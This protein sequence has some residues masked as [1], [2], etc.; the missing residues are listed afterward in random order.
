MQRCLH[1]RFVPPRVHQTQQASTSSRVVRQNPTMAMA[2]IQK[3]AQSFEIFQEASS[4]DRRPRI[5]FPR[6][7]QILPTILNIYE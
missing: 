4:G 2:K 1:L 7:M 6:Q 5:L 3:L